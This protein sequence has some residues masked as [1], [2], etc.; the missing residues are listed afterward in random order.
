MIVAQ[1]ADPIRWSWIG[2]NLDD[3][4]D[5]TLSHLQL[6]LVS[7]AIGLV[8]S[9]LL[10]VVATRYRRIYAPITSITGVLYTIPSIA[11]FPLLVPFTGLRDRTA[12][13]A[14]VLYTLLIL[15]RNT[16]AGLDGVPDDVRE[17]AIGMGYRRNRL[18]FEIDLPLALPV[19]IAGLRIATVTTVGLATIAAFI[20]TESLGFFI[21]DGFQSNMFVPKLV[22][23]A[24]VPMLLAILLD[25]LLL[26]IERML[27]PWS[28]RTRP[29]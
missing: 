21:F 7:V 17:S 12:I 19:I 10:A 25:A 22:V 29:A 4:W 11:L 23:G 5:K 15:F 3:I 16:V 27:T 6:T 2:Q 20:G 9:T 13:I 24:V 1:A 8:I 14:L 28:R 18:F 26:L